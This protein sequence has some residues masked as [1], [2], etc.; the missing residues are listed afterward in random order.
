MKPI[1]CN[2]T[3]VRFSLPPLMSLS[4]IIKQ[5]INYLIKITEYSAVPEDTASQQ[6]LEGKLNKHVTKTH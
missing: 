1:T 3:H 6:T 5:S 2:M 4:S